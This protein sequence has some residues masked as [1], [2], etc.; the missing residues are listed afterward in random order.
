MNDTIKSQHKMVFVSSLLFTTALVFRAPD[1]L[2]NAMYTK[3]IVLQ[4]VGFASLS[5]I[6]V[7]LLV[8]WTGFIRRYR[9]AWFVMFIIVWVWAFPAFLLPLFYGKIA[10][11]FVEWLEEAWH[12]PGFARI[13]G[14]N[15][16][17]VSIMVVALLLPL[18]VVLLEPKG[19]S[20]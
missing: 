18:K 3:D 11:T 4:T 12:W 14:E 19:S 15:I 8:V 13:Y 6:L 9:W 17:L 16:V 2:R 20:Q 7:G 1:C 10:V 5:N